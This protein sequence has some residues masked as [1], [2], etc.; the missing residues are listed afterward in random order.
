MKQQPIGQ[1]QLLQINMRMKLNDCLILDRE[2]LVKCAEDNLTSLLF[3]R[4]RESDIKEFLSKIRLNW[5]LESLERLDGS[6]VLR[7]VEVL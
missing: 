3:D 6:V 7:K 2:D 1:M 4:V 5:G